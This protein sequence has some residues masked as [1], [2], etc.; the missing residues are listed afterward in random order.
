MITAFVGVPGSGKTY[1]AVEKILQNIKLGRKIY[2][3]IDGVQLP[4]CKKAIAAYCDVRDFQL[5]TCLNHLTEEQ[6]RAFWLHCEP[7]SLVII[8]EVHKLFSNR[9]WQT[10]KNKHFTE[11]AST[12][13]HEGFDVVLIT[14]DLEKIDKHCRTLV[15]YVYLYSKVNFLGRAVSQKYICYTYHGDSHVGKP[16]ATSPRTYN[17]SIFPCYQSYVANE[18][19]EQA[20][21][22]KPNIFNHPVFYA[23]GAAFCLTSYFAFSSGIF[24]GEFMAPP[25]IG[26][27]AAVAEV[28]PVAEPKPKDFPKPAPSVVPGST[29]APESVAETKQRYPYL[30]LYRFP[31]GKEMWVNNGYV[32]PGG[33]LIRRI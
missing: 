19:E 22:K 7:G 17:K 15:E 1:E 8:D 11:W 6:S 23:L 24:S 16:M 13:R 9:E 31:N 26:P 33:I 27:S 3:N 12:H 18:V 21:M 32:P 30:D 14:Q 10:E 20:F 29:V 2:T 25:E 4:E 5:E 28:L